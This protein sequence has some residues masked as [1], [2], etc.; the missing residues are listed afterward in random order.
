M[1]NKLEEVLRGL[2]QIK[3]TKNLKQVTA[4]L[5]DKYLSSFGGGK[6]IAT[7]EKEVLSYILMRMR[8]THSATSFALQKIK[9]ETGINSVL[10]MGAGTGA[11]TIAVAERFD[12][13]C[14]DA[15]ELESNMIKANK[16]I[17]S[18]FDKELFNKITYI[19]ADATK[20]DITKKYDLVVT[21]YFLNEL[22]EKDRLKLAKN[23]YNS[24]NKYLVIVE[25]GTPKN[26]EEIMEIKRTLIGLGA[27]LISPCKSEVCP[28][29]EGD[30]WCHFITRIN[31]SKL[32]REIKGGSLGYEDEK[33]TYLVFS[34]EKEERNS[35]KIIIRKPIILKNKIQVRTCSNSGIETLVITKRDKEAYKN[36]KNMGVGDEF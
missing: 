25:P 18:N 13:E 15:V 29:L 31:R 6:P 30:D 20:L 32:Q 34:K 3:D 7:T 5:S 19:Q 11:A 36:I 24:T 4:N 12:I 8:A 2:E 1:E 9:E 26:H 22:K 14:I 27:K 23:L 21:S 16:E 28:L 33:F 17:L 35:S 10:D